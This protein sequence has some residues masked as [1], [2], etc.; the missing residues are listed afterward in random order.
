MHLNQFFFIKILNIS[1][2]EIASENVRIVL[3]IYESLYQVHAQILKLSNIQNILQ[4]QREIYSVIFYSF[5]LPP[6]N[7]RKF[8]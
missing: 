6:A 4:V 8:G 3:I 1:R 5:V 7:F 2:S